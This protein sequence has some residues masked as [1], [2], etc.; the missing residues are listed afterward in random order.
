[1]LLLLVI[2]TYCFYIVIKTRR[3][4][5][6]YYPNFFNDWIFPRHIQAALPPHTSRAFS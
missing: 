3:Y 4:P 2:T 6:P 1:M 5:V